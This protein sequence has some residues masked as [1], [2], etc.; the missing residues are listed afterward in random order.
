M[1]SIFNFQNGTFFLCLLTI[2]N[3]SYPRPC[4]NPHSF[5]IVL[6]ASA[7]LFF[8]SY[9]CCVDFKN[10]TI[11]CMAPSS[12]CIY[13]SIL[14]FLTCIVRCLSFTLPKPNLAEAASELR[15][16]NEDP[17]RIKENGI[18]QGNEKATDNSKNN[19]LHQLSPFQGC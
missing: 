17:K 10:V 2:P 14:L 12:V 18:K 6:N 3:P 11:F 8:V 19:F 7:T 5:T 13:Q 15:Q 9:V 4:L 16:G 1:L